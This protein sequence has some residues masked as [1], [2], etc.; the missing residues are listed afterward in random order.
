MLRFSVSRRLFRLAPLATLL[1]P[2]CVFARDA[3]VAVS[4][5]TAPTYDRQVPGQKEPRRETYVFMEGRFF[6]AR[7]ES[8]SLMRMPFMTIAQTLAV[9]LARQNYW[10]AP[11]PAEADLL[12]MVHWG[13]TET[14]EEESN[15][16]TTQ[17]LNSAFSDV[18]SAG[19]ADALPD[20][21]AL[22]AELADQAMREGLR[23][24]YRERNAKL[25]G[26][27]V[28]MEKESRHPFGSARELTL[29]SELSEGRYF[30]I[31]MA[32][33][34]RALRTEKRKE[35]LWITRLSVQGR[36]SNFTEALPA[37]SFV[38]ADYFGRR[39]LDLGHVRT[40]LEEAL[41][42]RA[43]TE[44]GELQVIENPSPPDD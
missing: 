42:K 35:V 1:V 24:R 7:Q 12:L 16:D 43:V 27:N 13:L 32:Y 31:V 22:N 21:S 40:D 18:Q 4:A 10:P 2:L 17:R 8:A 6:P 30:V 3:R 20:V 5:T 14:Y 33:D 41:R 28:A 26:Y 9:D 25:L 11:D 36:G 34:Y 37:L 44:I 39:E 15:L 38:G 23:A 19:A 29:R